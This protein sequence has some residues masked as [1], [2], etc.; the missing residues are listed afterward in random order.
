MTAPT[1]LQLTIERF[2]GVRALTWLPT[3]GANIILGGG[4][5]GKTTILDAVA[6]LLAPTNAS[7]LSDADYHSRNL[8][9]GFRIEAVMSLPPERISGQTLKPSW[10]WEWRDGRAVVPAIGEEGPVGASVYVLRVSGTPELELL[11]EIVQP[12]GDADH[13]PVGL[14]RAIGIIRLSGDDRNDRDLRLVQGSALERLLSD[15][16]LRSR[17]G[18]KLAQSD[19]KAELQEDAKRALIDLD[20]AFK[21]KALPDGLDLAVTGAQGITITALIGLTANRDG[22]QLPLSNWGSGTRRLSALAIAEQNQNDFSITL[23]D[24]VERGLEPYRQRALVE[25]LQGAPSQAFITTHSTSAVSAAT[26]S[27]LWYLD[28]T[29]AIGRLD[30]AKIA[31]HQVREPEAFL[32]RFTIVAEGAT[33]VGFLSALLQRAL[34]ASLQTYGITVSDGSGHENALNLLE[35]LSAGGLKFGGF[36]DNE[37]GLHPE[38]WRRIQE[39][40]G[41]LLFRWQNGCL[42]ENL[43]PAVPADRLEELI[44]HPEDGPANRLR[45]LAVRLGIEDKAIPAL[46]ATAGDGLVALIIEAAKGTVP[47]GKEEEKKIYKSHAG[48]W[49]KSI[50]GGQ[51]IAAKMFA[52]G[53]WPQF[54]PLLMPFLN[55]VR[56]AVDLPEIEDLPQ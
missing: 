2:R 24:E 36:A 55:A 25:K 14:R 40:L 48:T 19:V 41:P 30:G 17:L 34:G 28:H 35:A 44:A 1:I 29:G 6:L 3:K 7:T 42:E 49:F 56:A 38:R 18:N 12:N 52:M 22:V 9:E 16:G 21:A 43:I 39:R 32:S 11:Y 47:A 46:R 31:A 50:E 15:R 51:E 54:K 23:V 26:S 8:A 45:T 10:P 4:D 5:A 27:A 53:L 13:L 37:G 33:E 20:A